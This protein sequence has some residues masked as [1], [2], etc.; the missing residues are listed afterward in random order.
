MSAFDPANVA[1]WP[2]V[3]TIQHMTAI[4]SRTVIGLRKAC[5]R[6]T[7]SPLP[8]RTRPYQWRKV[9]VVRDVEGARQTT[10]LR[11]VS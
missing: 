1:T 10:G 11:R 4:Y 6:G 7:F 2:M 3:L 8:Y 9:D 5:Q